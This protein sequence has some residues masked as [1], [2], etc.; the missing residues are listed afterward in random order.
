MAIGAG[1]NQVGHT[2]ATLDRHE[3]SGVRHVIL[4]FGSDG[5][6]LRRFGYGHA[7]RTYLRGDKEI[8]CAPHREFYT[9]ADAQAVVEMVNAR[10]VQ[11]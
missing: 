3:V 1:N 8:E 6:L 4:R 2:K 11:S 5:R 10:A 9:D 7:V